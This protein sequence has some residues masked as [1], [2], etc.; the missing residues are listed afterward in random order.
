MQINIHSVD[1]G[2]TEESAIVK[3]YNDLKNE[4]YD[5]NDNALSVDHNTFLAELKRIK[6]Q[7]D[8]C[9]R[10]NQ[11]SEHQRCELL[12]ELQIPKSEQ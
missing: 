7:I 5:F 3:S 8:F 2:K 4:I 10:S 1:L 11:I 6:N 9:K 12:D